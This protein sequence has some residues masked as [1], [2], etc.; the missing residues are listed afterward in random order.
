MGVMQNDIPNT[1]TSKKRH[2][3]PGGKPFWKSLNNIGLNNWKIW[4]VIRIDTASYRIVGQTYGLPSQK[5]DR[6]G[7][8]PF[9][10]SI[11]WCQLDV[12]WQLWPHD[13]GLA[14]GCVLSVHRSTVASVTR[15]TCQLTTSTVVIA[16]HGVSIVVLYL[17][18]PSRCS[19]FQGSSK[20]IS[21]YTLPS[22]SR[23]MW[24]EVTLSDSDVT[25]VMTQWL[26]WRVNVP[27]GNLYNILMSWVA[28]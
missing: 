4:L 25:I 26:A 1:C 18:P 9:C 8:V 15:I 3:K 27:W 19:Y 13:E 5:C 28:R 14:C 21:R 11:D 12:I 2:K 24:S 10:W 16:S 22:L 23:K 17:L 7:F 20:M 6:S